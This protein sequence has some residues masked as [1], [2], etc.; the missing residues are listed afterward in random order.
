MVLHTFFGPECRLA[1]E[2]FPGSANGSGSVIEVVK[3]VVRLETKH[4][5]QPKTNLFGFGSMHAALTRGT[6]RNPVPDRGQVPPSLAATAYQYR[7][8]GVRRIDVW[9]EGEP[10]FDPSH[11]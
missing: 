6:G 7:L 11:Y 4:L 8:P 2:V 3:L 5:E 9:P 10:E 1:L